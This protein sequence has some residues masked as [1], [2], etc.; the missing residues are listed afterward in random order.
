MHVNAHEVRAIASSLVHYSG[1]SIKDIMAGGRWESSG[2]FFNHYWR[3]MASALGPMS[4][5]IVAAGQL[6]RRK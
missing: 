1:A 4:T 5:A 3:D 6:V 2:S